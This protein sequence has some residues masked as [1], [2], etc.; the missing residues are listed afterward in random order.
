MI[1]SNTMH[2]M[3]IEQGWYLVSTSKYYPINKETHLICP[4]ALQSNYC[5]HQCISFPDAD[6][7]AQ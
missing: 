5:L 7:K 3:Y 1:N 4:K 6:I 2:K